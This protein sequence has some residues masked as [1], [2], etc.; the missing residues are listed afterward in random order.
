MGKEY[1]SVQP[2]TNGPIAYP[3]AGDIAPNLVS[4]EPVVADD[5]DRDEFRATEFRRTSTGTTAVPGDPGS[6]TETRSNHS[7]H[8]GHGLEEDGLRLPP[9]VRTT[10]G[11]SGKPYSSFSQGMKWMIVTLAGIAAV[12][13]P[14]RYVSFTSR[15]DLKRELCLY[16]VQTSLCPPS[17]PFLVNSI[18]GKNKS[19]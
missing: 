13:S 3:A 11:A 19:H 4:S 15:D 17:R 9:T 10:T 5:I 8:R 1:P 14:I 18:E 7:D 6:N 12:F 2:G 16:P